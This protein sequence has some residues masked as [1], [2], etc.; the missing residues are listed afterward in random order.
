MIAP[1]SRMSLRQN[2][3]VWNFLLGAVFITSI[4][5]PF[6]Q[7]TSMFYYYKLRNVTQM[8]ESIVDPVT[9]YLHNLNHYEQV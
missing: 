1:K 6:Q 9:E 8:P 7:F 3:Y 4:R 5:E 2:K